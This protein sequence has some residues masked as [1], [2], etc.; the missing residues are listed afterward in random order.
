MISKY[1]LPS[2]VVNH[3]YIRQLI[4]LQQGHEL[5][6][7]HK[8]KLCHVSLTQ[9]EKMRVNLAAQFFSRSTASA[10]ELCVRLELLP[11]DTLT[12]A[13][14]INFVND[15]FDVLNA[16]HKDAVL[17]KVNGTAKTEILLEMPKLRMTFCYI[18]ESRYEIFCIGRITAPYIIMYK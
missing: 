4:D 15:W 1:N 17:F 10:L 8:L 7:A 9:Y 3:T 5:R 18:T 2:D 13:W 11:T 6:V 14:F 12:I 16:R